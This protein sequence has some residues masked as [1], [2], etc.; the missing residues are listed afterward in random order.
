MMFAKESI[1]RDG[2]EKDILPKIENY[3]QLF[4]SAA[5]FN[6]GYQSTLGKEICKM[7]GK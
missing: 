7:I 2:K 5:V 1:P 3:Y 6:D 4:P